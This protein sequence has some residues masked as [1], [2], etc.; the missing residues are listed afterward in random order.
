MT[1]TYQD[2]P[3]VVMPVNSSQPFCPSCLGYKKV[4]GCGSDYCI[5]SVI[6]YKKVIES[7]FSHDLINS[8]VSRHIDEYSSIDCPKCGYVS[9]IY[10]R[11]FVS[12]LNKLKA[13]DL[14]VLR[15]K[16]SQLQISI[17]F[18]GDLRLSLN[19][20]V[21]AVTT[22]TDFSQHFGLKLDLSFSEVSKHIVLLESFLAAVYFK[23]L[24]ILEEKASKK[25]K[26]A[27]LS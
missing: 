5:T 16:K 27:A 4:C 24:L 20:A 6:D 12:F 23:E 11:D 14:N 21:S 9:W 13:K 7:G 15:D 8:L 10:N 3:R 1:I 19:R 17:D 25:V 2:L 22:E 18:C 26:K